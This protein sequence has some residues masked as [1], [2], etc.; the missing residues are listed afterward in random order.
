MRAYSCHFVVGS[1]RLFPN[2]P[3]IQ[4][5]LDWTG[6]QKYAVKFWRASEYRRR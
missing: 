4:L 3:Q 1:I 5:I 2:L 6:T